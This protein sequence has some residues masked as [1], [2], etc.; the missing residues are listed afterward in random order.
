M[1][2]PPLRLPKRVGVGLG[3]VKGFEFYSVGMIPLFAEKDEQL[4]IQGSALECL[5][6]RGFD[7]LANVEELFKLGR[8]EPDDKWG[9]HWAAQ[10]FRVDLLA[11]QQAYA[12]TC[13]PPD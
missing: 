7:R 2:D 13:Y 3:K 1:A 5:S 8:C 12:A 6:F 4:I 11:P 9:G 10:A